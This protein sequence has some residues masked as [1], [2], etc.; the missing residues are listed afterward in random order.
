MTSTFL[1]IR[2]LFSFR[3]PLSMLNTWECVCDCDMCGGN[4]EIGHFVESA[5]WSRRA[6]N[7]WEVTCVHS[8]APDS[9]VSSCILW[10]LL[11]I[12]FHHMLCCWLNFTYNWVIELFLKTSGPPKYTVKMFISLWLNIQKNTQHVQSGKQKRQHSK[13]K[14]NFKWNKHK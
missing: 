3:L 14:P 2:A 1:A 9:F 7:K 10:R 8:R 11:S 6:N 13:A 4:G 5:F 12:C